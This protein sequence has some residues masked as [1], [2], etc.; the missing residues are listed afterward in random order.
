MVSSKLKNIMKMSEMGD[1]REI[2]QMV[3]EKLNKSH[4]SFLNKWNLFTKLT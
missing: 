2:Y 3:Q 1:K 4:K